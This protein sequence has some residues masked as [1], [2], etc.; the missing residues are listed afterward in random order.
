[1]KLDQKLY[2][3]FCLTWAQEPQVTLWNSC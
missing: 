1:M 2:F 3:S